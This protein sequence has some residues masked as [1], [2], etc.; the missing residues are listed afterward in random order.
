MSEKGCDSNAECSFFSN[1]DTSLLSYLEPGDHAIVTA[2]TSSSS[3]DGEVLSQ[4]F[5]ASFF[6][7]LR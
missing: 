2:V 3:D 5:L 6:W 4:K 1:S 7:T